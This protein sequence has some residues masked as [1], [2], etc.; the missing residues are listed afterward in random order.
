MDHPR[1]LRH[2]ADDEAVSLGHRLLRP[3]VGRED[4]GR[5][6]VAAVGDRAPPTPRAR[7]RGRGPCG[8]GTP[9]TPVESTTTCSGASPSAVPDL[10]SGSFGVGDSRRAGRS[11]GDAGVDHD[12]LRLGELEV[13][14]RHDDRS[15]EHA[16][17]RPHGRPDGRHRGADDREI[18][19]GAADARVNTARDESLSGRDRHQTRT[20]ESRSPVVSSSPKRTLTFWIA[21]PAAP[22]PRLSSAQMTIVALASSDPRRRRSRR[23]PSAGRARA[24]GRPRPAARRRRD[25]PR[26]APRAVHADRRHASGRRR[27]R[28]ARAAPAGGAART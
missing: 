28:A 6:R 16:I 13:P 10:G 26:S 25:S 4:R 22:F 12:R 8:S 7:P 21:W 5:S 20:P 24:P 14:L 1:A 3:A 2:P 15:R 18:R 19:P 23:R 11:V 17:R 9:M 27:S